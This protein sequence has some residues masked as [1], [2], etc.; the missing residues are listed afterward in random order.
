MNALKAIL[1]LSATVVLCSLKEN[2]SCLENVGKRVDI[3]K[4][5]FPLWMFC[6]VVLDKACRYTGK[7]NVLKKKNSSV[8]WRRGQC[9]GWTNPSCA[10]PA[11]V[12]CLTL[13]K[14]YVQ[15]SPSS[16]QSVSPRQERCSLA[17]LLW[18]IRKNKEASWCVSNGSPGKWIHKAALDSGL[19]LLLMHV[20]GCC[21][22][23]VDTDS[24]PPK[25]CVRRRKCL[26]PCSGDTKAASGFI[27]FIFKY[28]YF[29]WY[30][31]ERNGLISLHRVTTS[32]E[33]LGAL[34]RGYN[35]KRNECPCLRAID[36][37]CWKKTG[38]GHPVPLPLPS[39]HSLIHSFSRYLVSTVC[40]G[41]VVL[42][43]W[44]RQETSIL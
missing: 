11:S 25:S 27:S 38:W 40:H 6:R 17:H 1:A 43:N 29:I 14:D 2:S 24:C 44:N 41:S 33:S 34:Q 32:S 39:I 15:T 5:G 19:H 22:P 16:E 4:S 20:S 42:G 8:K 23:R 12:A 37:L 10:F 13:F 35:P 31:A 18:N 36:Q 28:L 30:I 9:E 26:C 7:G 21:R 3:R